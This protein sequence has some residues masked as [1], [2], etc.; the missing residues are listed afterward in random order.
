MSKAKTVKKAKAAEDLNLVDPMQP[1]PF[2]ITEIRRELTDTFTMVLVPADGKG[3]SGFAPG[4]FNMLYVH[5][6]GEVPISVSGD[7]T[8]QDVLV[9]T[10]RAVGKVSRAL[11]TL[12]VGATVGVRGP[13][14]TPWPVAAAEGK[15]LVFVAGGIGLAPLR[16]AI[17]RA[18]HEREKFKNLAILYGA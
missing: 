18:L 16:P 4:Q 2:R 5:G 17:Y 3:P 13:F 7:P 8:N 9:H 10:T 6:I 1:R 14:G 12:K 11:D 15:D